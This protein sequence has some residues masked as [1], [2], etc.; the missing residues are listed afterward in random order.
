MS[1]KQDM[2]SIDHYWFHQAPLQI[3]FQKSPSSCLLTIHRLQA[4]QVDFSRLR[5]SFGRFTTF[6]RPLRALKTS[7]RFTRGFGWPTRDLRTSVTSRFWS[8][9]GMNIH[10]LEVGITIIIKNKVRAN[11]RLSLFVDRL[12]ERLVSSHVLHLP[13]FRA[14]DKKRSSMAGECE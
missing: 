13:P 1:A 5:P 14:K 8:G 2:C 7:H 3:D 12:E 11:L 9:T 6:A 10:V 4:R